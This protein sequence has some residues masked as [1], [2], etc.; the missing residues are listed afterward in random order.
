MYHFICWGNTYL[1]QF[2]CQS[3][4]ISYKVA[5]WS[6][7]TVLHASSHPKLTLLCI[8]YKVTPLHTHVHCTGWIY[9]YI[10]VAEEGILYQFTY[11]NKFCI[12]LYAKVYFTIKKLLHRC[13][14]PGTRHCGLVAATLLFNASQTKFLGSELIVGRKLFAVA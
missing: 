1:Y 13:K 3:N 6:N 10:S 8:H 11:W 4:V 14:L 5:V 2:T 7:I 12:R 9:T